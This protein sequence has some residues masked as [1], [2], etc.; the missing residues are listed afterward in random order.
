MYD[1]SKP[2][3][4]IPLAILAAAANTACRSECTAP[5]PE[6]LPGTILETGCVDTTDP[7]EMADGVFPYAVAQTFWSDGAEK[8]RWFSLPS[9]A[10]MTVREDGRWELP[11]GAVTI[12][13]FRRNDRLFETRFFVRDAADSYH[14]YTYRWNADETDAQL[15]TAQGESAQIDPT[16]PWQYPSRAQCSQCHNAS[17]GYF[18]G[19]Q[20]RQLN[21]DIVDESLG[22]TGNQ[23]AQLDSLGRLHGETL[24]GDI[25]PAAE[26]PLQAAYSIDPNA[27]DW[28]L[29]AVIDAGPAALERAAK[30]YLAV[31]C[32][33]CH[34]KTGWN[35]NIF[36]NLFDARFDTPLASSEL[37]EAR[38]SNQLIVPGNAEA[39]TL[40]RRQSVRDASRMP[41]IGTQLPDTAGSELLAAWINGMQECPNP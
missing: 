19:F 34:N 5:S 33:Y 24:S 30:S 16:L 21:I 39:S 2:S 36:S 15:V 26:I 31:N 41:N 8:D 11:V 3:A 23:I 14:G 29:L 6:D 17:D 27:E 9:R 1:Q 18:L 4:L 40:Y 7:R 12:K 37:C 13:N 25:V 20:T 32:G 22:M 28:D 38:A 35:E 10:S